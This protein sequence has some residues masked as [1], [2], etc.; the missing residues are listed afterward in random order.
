MSQSFGRRTPILMRTS[1]L[2][3]SL[4]ELY[5]LLHVA[6]KAAGGYPTYT[7]IHDDDTT[8]YSTYYYYY[9]YPPYI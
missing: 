4:K 1:T 3:C 8:Y 2:A 9:I 5:T 7:Y 6:G